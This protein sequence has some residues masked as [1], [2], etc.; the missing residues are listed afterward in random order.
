MILQ[1][2]KEITLGFKFYLV[3]SHV[4]QKFTFYHISE[5]LFHFLLRLYYIMCLCDFWGVCVYIMGEKAVTVCYKL[6]TR[7][8][9]L[10]PFCLH[11][12]LW[13]AMEKKKKKMLNLMVTVDNS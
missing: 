7:A 9:A 13:R 8:L 6:K 5:S 4:L 12:I 11:L 2:N 3:F 10:S 1:K